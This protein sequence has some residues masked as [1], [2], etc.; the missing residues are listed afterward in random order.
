MSSL[1]KWVL[2][3]CGPIATRVLS[4]LGLSLVTYVGVDTAVN[5]CI[6]YIRNSYSGVSADVAVFLAMG[7]FNTALGIV[8]GGIVSH[9]TLMQFKRMKFK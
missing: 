1:T 2:S 3:V 9:L 7:G 8:C 5:Y 4:Q 6:D